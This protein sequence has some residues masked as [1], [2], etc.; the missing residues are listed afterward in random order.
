MLI[1]MIPEL[2]KQ[3]KNVALVSVISSSGSTPAE[4]GKEM[5][6]DANGIIDGT[7]GGGNLEFR[8]IKV[9]HRNSLKN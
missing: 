3:N 7:V 4:V 1:E 6:V 9:S 5:I 2:V 8:A